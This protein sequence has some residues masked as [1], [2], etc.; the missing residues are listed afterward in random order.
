MRK[1]TTRQTRDSV[2]LPV[3]GSGSPSL[4]LSSARRKPEDR[5][6]HVACSGPLQ[7]D[8]TPISGLVLKVQIPRLWPGPLR[9]KSL[10]VQPGNL[11]LLLR[12]RLRVVLDITMHSQQVSNL[13]TP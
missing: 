3:D 2:P 6:E 5:A 4:G 13:A 11:H 10:S 7:P 1:T 12:L 9:S 8:I